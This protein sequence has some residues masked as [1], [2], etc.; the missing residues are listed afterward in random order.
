V[1]R[2][3]LVYT[4]LA[5]TA[6]AYPKSS[7]TEARFIGDVPL[8]TPGFCG[9]RAERQHGTTQARLPT[10]LHRAA[11]RCEHRS[12]WLA[13]P[14]GVVPYSKIVGRG[15]TGGARLL[16]VDLSYGPLFRLIL[17]GQ[18]K[19]LK[20][21]LRLLISSSTAGVRHFVT[22]SVDPPDVTR[23]AEVFFA[24]VAATWQQWRRYPTVSGDSYTDL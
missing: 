4:G 6:V 3:L 10:L 24:Q 23:T 9:V 8:A 1:P 22:V 18:S 5:V 15:V 16:A 20:E 2:R 11:L 12:Q 21:N 14:L 7:K 17:V 19:G 13:P